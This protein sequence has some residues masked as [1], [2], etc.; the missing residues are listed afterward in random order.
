[1]R[2]L[3]ALALL[4][5]ALDSRAVT[6]AADASDLWWNPNESGWGLNV[7]QQD[8]TL[9]MTFFIYAANGQPIWLVA[10]A[11]IF[12]AQSG[13]SLIY[14]GPLYVTA[15]PWFG[16]PFNPAAVG[17]SQVG[18][19]TFTLQSIVDASLTY[20]ANGVVATKQLKRQTWK[21]NSLV[22]SYIG[23]SVGV[24]SGN[25]PTLGYVEEP[26]TI[27]IST[28]TE[29]FQMAAQSLLNGVLCTYRGAPATQ[30]G[31]MSTAQGSFQCTNGGAGTFVS[32]EIQANRWGFTGI[33]A[34]SFS[35]GCSWIGRLG[36]LRRGS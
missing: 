27:A 15:G 29:G 10:P 18:T 13:I 24:Y 14:S 34:A 32:T 33:A 9:F 26:D 6:F 16:G 28:G 31:Q 7:A 35:N 20:S 5:T 3:L 8:N 36:G 1:M 30:D 22:G 12:T 17:A 25:C 4:I 2:K 21:I 23:A 11:T 19:A